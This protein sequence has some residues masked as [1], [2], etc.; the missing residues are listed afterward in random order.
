MV[1]IFLAMGM[2]Q[3]RAIFRAESRERWR[4]NRAAAGGDAMMKAAAKRAWFRLWF[5]AF[6][7]VMP[8]WLIA[9]VVWDALAAAID[10]LAR[11]CGYQWA[12]FKRE[13]F[14]DA[15]R[16][17]WRQLKRGGRE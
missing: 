12:D 4:A 1:P 13:D 10:G 17:A 2:R 3:A 8:A 5:G 15:Y 7:L 9:C 16:C 6:V 11:E 14:A